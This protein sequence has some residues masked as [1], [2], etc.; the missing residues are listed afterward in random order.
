MIVLGMVLNAYVSLVAQ[1]GN[2]SCHGQAHAFREEWADYGATLNQQT[3][4]LH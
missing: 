1:W 3:S 2:Y 4:F